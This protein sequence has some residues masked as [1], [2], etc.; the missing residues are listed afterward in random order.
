MKDRAGLVCR[1]PHEADVKQ[2]QSEL[3]ALTKS[4]AEM[5]KIRYET[6]ADYVTAKAELE[7]GLEGVRKALSILRDYYGSGAAMLQDSAEQPAPPQKFSKAGGVG[8]SII[9]ILEVVES[10]FAKSLAKDRVPASG[11]CRCVLLTR[12]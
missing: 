12:S 7:Q 5:D 6:H 2:F 9:G 10:D 4:Q 11:E 1:E 3:A 8:T